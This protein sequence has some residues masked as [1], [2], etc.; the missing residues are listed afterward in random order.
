VNYRIINDDIIHWAENYDSEPF[1]CLICDPPYHLTQAQ[2]FANSNPE[3]EQYAMTANNPHARLARSGFMGKHWDGGDIAFQPE[4]W[5]A[6]AE[7]LYPG[8]FLLVFASSRGWHRLA[9]A[10]EDSGLRMHPSIFGWGA[11]MLLWNFGSGFPK[12]TRIDTQI[13][14]AAGAEVVKGKAFNMKDS[15]DADEHAAPVVPLAQAW[16]GHRYGLQALKPA[17]EVILMFQKPYAGKPVDSITE[18]GAGAINIEE[19]RIGAQGGETHQGGFRGSYGSSEEVKTDRSKRGRWPANFY[20]SHLPPIQCPNTA[21]HQNAEDGISS[22]EQCQ[23]CHGTGMV[24]QCKRVGERRVKKQGGAFT[25]RRDA[26]GMFGL[27]GDGGQNIDHCDADGLE[28]VTDWQCSEDCPVAKLDKFIG[29][30]SV[31][32]KRSQCSQDAKVTGTQF[33]PNNHR[34]T[35][36]PH[37]SGGPSR[38]FFNSDWNYEIAERLAT[39]DPV[40]YCAKASRKER[41]MGLAEWDKRP[42]GAYVMRNA[43]DTGRDPNK[44][45]NAQMGGQTFG[46]NRHPCIKPLKL[47]EWLSKLLLPPDLYAPRRILIPFSGSGSEG[48][49]ALLAG[50]EEIVMIDSEEEYCEIAE[51]RMAYWKKEPRQDKLL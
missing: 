48:I 26:R 47:C 28:T 15:S 37:D 4:T 34:S 7:H 23:I 43:V 3:K 22:H 12:S 29:K 10:L 16:A 32:G 24:E 11:P 42:A 49:G 14:K 39:C 5:A 31:T 20:L 8:A 35:E 18:T 17:V 19:A 21:F 13:D 6:L 36:Y 50:F 40:F 38:F 27:G 33:L 25:Y 2:R 9:C 51:A 41:D 1:H 45:G 46:R 30:T 44:V